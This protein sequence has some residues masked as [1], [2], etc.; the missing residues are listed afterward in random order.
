MPST[1][2]LTNYEVDV[3]VW[4]AFETDRTD[5]RLINIDRSLRLACTFMAL[6]VGDLTV[7]AA[8][9][10]RLANTTDKHLARRQTLVACVTNTLY[11]SLL[12]LR[13]Y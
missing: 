11:E 13:E 5:H 4:P 2:H 3:P 9:T 6:P 1:S 12:L 7:F 8:V 10:H